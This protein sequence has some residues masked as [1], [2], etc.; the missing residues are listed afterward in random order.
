MDYGGFGLES[1]SRRLPIY[2]LIDCSESM[3]GE[4]LDAVNRGLQQLCTDLKN[5]PMAIETAWL[6][7]ITFSSRARQVIP[8]TDVVQFAPPILS[9]GPGTSMG[10]AFDLLAQRLDRE[11]RKNTPTQKGDWKPIVFL[12]TDGIPTDNWEQAIK[13]FKKNTVHM[14]INVIAVGCGED[15]DVDVLREITPNVLLM[16][17]LSLGGFAAFFRWVS[18]SVST[19][20]V[21]ATREGQ[22]VNL[23]APPAGEFEFVGQGVVKPPASRRQPSQIILAARCQGNRQGYLM[24]YRRTPPSSD[25][26]Q[27]E[28]AYRVGNDYFTEASASPSGQKIDTSKLKGS[29]P[30]PYCGRLGWTL[31]KDKSSLICSDRLEL[32]GK[33]AQVMFVLDV[34]GSMWGE[35]EGVKMNIKDFMDYIHSEGLSVDVG[36]IA[37]RDLEMRERPELLKFEGRPFTNDA[38]DFKSKVSKLKASGGGSNP[39]ESSFDALVLASQQ[40]FKEDVAR[41]LILIT[42]EPPLIPDGEVRSIEDVIMALNKGG[43]D[44]LHIVIPDHLKS[45]YAPLHRHVKG[46]IFRLGAGGR[47]GASFRKILMDIGKSISVMTRLG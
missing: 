2:I 24:R 18:A 6:S 36:L 10:A 38:R 26:Y 44:Q 5:D 27:A 30:C 1:F 22:G 45:H 47:G 19:A 28:K 43:I 17:N 41:I 11:V 12:L 7:V 39:G 4:P 20:S 15:V 32:D 37:F 42:D 40:P 21:S 8:L 13:R 33:H 25:I 31:D 9:V 23:P 34:T 3:I 16:K 14:A 35:I 46:Q 29:P